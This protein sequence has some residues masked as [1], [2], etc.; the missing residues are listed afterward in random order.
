MT[1]K[2]ERSGR[3]AEQIFPLPIS[4]PDMHY[5]HEA[6]L[7]MAEATGFVKNHLEATRIT[8]GILNSCVKT[9]AGPLHPKIICVIRMHFKPRRSGSN[10]GCCLKIQ[11]STYFGIIIINRCRSVP[12]VNE[13]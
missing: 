5:G 3:M 4:I 8:S 7:C 6:H 10:R 11:T 9:A 12:Y 2:R 13:R 1:E